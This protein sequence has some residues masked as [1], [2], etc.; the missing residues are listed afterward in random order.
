[1]E[2]KWKIYKII[3]TLESGMV[4]CIDFHIANLVEP[5]ESVVV[6]RWYL[7][8]TSNGIY[9]A[10]LRVKNY[11]LPEVEESSFLDLLVVTGLI[12]AS[13][14]KMWSKT[15]KEVRER[16]SCHGCSWWMI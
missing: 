1:M 12:Q 11:P 14:G 2:A 10:G 7:D 6:V 9:T 16:G 13:L 15:Q 4:D 5:E 8:G 3:T